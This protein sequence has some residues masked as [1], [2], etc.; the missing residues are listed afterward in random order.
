LPST[1]KSGFL[2]PVDA[3][4][5]LG[6]QPH[7]PQGVQRLDQRQA[8]VVALDEERLRRAADRI[9]LVLAP[10][11]GDIALPGPLEFGADVGGQGLPVFRRGGEGLSVKAG[12]A[13]VEATRARAWRREGR[14]LFMARA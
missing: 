12:A 5:E 4:L 9:D 1:S 7:D 8:Q 13:A 6:V 3:R 2:D 10:G 14:K 11:L